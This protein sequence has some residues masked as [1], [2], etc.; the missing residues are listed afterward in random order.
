MQ[1]FVPDSYEGAMQQNAR[2]E[3]LILDKSFTGNK[4]DSL[5]VE[6]DSLNPTPIDEK[7][8]KHQQNRKK[9]LRKK[10]KKDKSRI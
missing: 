2:N 6:R 5:N 9:K 7:D 3:K 10:T 4:P 8:S 1:N